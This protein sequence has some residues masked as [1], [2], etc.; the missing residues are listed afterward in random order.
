MADQPKKSRLKTVLKYFALFV[1]V[2]IVCVGLYMYYLFTQIKAIPSEWEQAVAMQS[3]FEGSQSPEGESSTPQ[4]SA[5]RFEQQ[6]TSTFTRIRPQT[7]EWDAAISQQ[8]ANNWLSERLNKWVQNQKA[9]KDKMPSQVK[10]VLVSLTDN[11]AK[12][13]CA[14]EVKGHQFILWGDLKP[15]MVKDELHVKLERLGMG[16]EVTSVETASTLLG[17]VLSEKELKEIEKFKEPIKV[18]PFPLQ[19]K[20]EVDA[21]QIQ[22]KDKLIVGKFK[23]RRK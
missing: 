11:N 5:Q 9:L 8:Q 15:V 1:L 7:E 19:D 16:E 17:N 13:M 22:I 3:T 21:V 4:Q 23:T 6:L 10:K 12:L 2:V 20:R 14:I 18:P